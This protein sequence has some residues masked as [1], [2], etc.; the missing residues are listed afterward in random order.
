MAAV[1]NEF[2]AQKAAWLRELIARGLI[3]PGEVD[4]RSIEDVCPDD[5]RGFNQVHLFAGLGAWSYAAR[6]AG[7]DD[8]ESF[9]SCSC[10]CQ[11]FSSAGKGGGF[12][13]ERH[14]WPAVFHLIGALRPQR[15]VGEQVAS[16]DGRAW[17]DLVH[18]DMD[19]AEYACRVVNLSAAG[20]GAPHIRQR[21][22][23]VAD[24]SESE[25]GRWSRDGRGHDG[26]GPAA[27]R[28]QDPSHAKRR[29]E[30]GGLEYAQ[31]Q[32]G[33]RPQ[34]PTRQAGWDSPQ[35]PSATGGL[36]NANGRHAEQFEGPWSRPGGADGGRP[37]GEPAGPSEACG[38][39][40]LPLVGPG[41]TNGFWAGA[42]WV[43]CAD[44]DGPRWRPVEPWSFPLAHGSSARVGRL[45]G[46][47]DAIVAPLAEAFLRC[48]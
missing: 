39:R 17:F 19:A 6:R 21:L 10:P 43:L 1:Y 16:R 5:Y 32:R 23:W 20:V 4:Q 34:N 27:G 8:S 38:D 35:E 3:A 14:L 30:L 45:R 9:W 48:L 13:D 2:D 11:P 41:P 12:A 7:W 44:P 47:G 28:I 24:A 15:V 46:Y 31:G 42:D 22:Y 37:H 36:E 25:R 29:G 18:A 40:A 26:D 33:D